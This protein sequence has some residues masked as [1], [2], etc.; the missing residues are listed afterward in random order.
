MLRQG[1]AREGLEFYQ[2]CPPERSA[3]AFLDVKSFR[4]LEIVGLRNLK[5]I[6]R[7]ESEEF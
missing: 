7:S 4:R 1:S 6:K 2:A 3:R 5:S